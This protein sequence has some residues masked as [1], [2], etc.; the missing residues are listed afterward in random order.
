MPQPFITAPTRS[1]N[2][3]NVC[4]SAT[5]RS[6]QGTSPV[7]RSNGT[8]ATW[9]RVWSADGGKAAA[10]EEKGKK[11]SKKK[12]KSGKKSKKSKKGARQ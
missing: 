8:G 1:A 6:S 4:G 10:G 2:V 3:R 12:K 11:K 7:Q 5:G 9:G